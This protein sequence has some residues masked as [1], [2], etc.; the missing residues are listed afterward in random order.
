[1]ESGDLI[2]QAGTALYGRRWE[3]ALAR[4]LGVSNRTVRYWL[5][6]RQ[7]PPAGVWP[8]LLRLV[9]ART[10]QTARVALELVGRIG[11]NLT[12]AS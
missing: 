5:S 8:H 9:R 10:Q 3:T 12:G 7:E 1:M 4:D 11:V 2:R 6:G